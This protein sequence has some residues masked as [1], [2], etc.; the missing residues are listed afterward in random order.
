M[1]QYYFRVK[2]TSGDIEC[3]LE[4]ETGGPYKTFKTDIRADYCSLGI[5]LQNMN[6]ETFKQ[7]VDVDYSRRMIIDKTEILTRE[8]AKQRR[9]DYR[10]NYPEYF[11]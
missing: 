10:H 1:I 6:E 11:I 3:T 2:L 9:L 4:R 5:M 8:E 7:E